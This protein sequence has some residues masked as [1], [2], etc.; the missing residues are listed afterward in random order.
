[1]SMEGNLLFSWGSGAPSPATHWLSLS[2][3]LF[4]TKKGY[5]EAAF[6]NLVGRAGFNGGA[7]PSDRV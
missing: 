4:R 6:F 2:L 1:M 5:P 7:Q 3:T